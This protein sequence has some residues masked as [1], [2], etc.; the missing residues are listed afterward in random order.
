MLSQHVQ[1]NHF[2][3]FIKVIILRGGYVVASLV[4]VSSKLM[5]VY[6][7]VFVLH[8]SRAFSFHLVSTTDSLGQS[9]VEFSAN[10]DR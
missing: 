10:D 7:A 6:V 4:L 8:M 2:K 5:E 1:Y 9:R 3:F